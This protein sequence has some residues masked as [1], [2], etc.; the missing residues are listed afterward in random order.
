MNFG[1]GELGFGAWPRVKFRPGAEY[2]TVFK[3]STPMALEALPMTAFAS[4]AEGVQT[5]TTNS[6][7]TARDFLN[8]FASLFALERQEGQEFAHVIQLLQCV[9]TLNNRFRPRGTQHR[10]HQASR[11]LVH[12]LRVQR[13]LLRARGVTGKVA[14]R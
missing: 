9:H 1:H 10:R 13:I 4:C 14:H 3:V 7:K 6:P 12:A 2:C 5:S 8:M 11:L